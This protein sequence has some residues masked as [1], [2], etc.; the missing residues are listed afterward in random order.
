MEGRE[1]PPRGGKA[2]AGAD[3]E[4]R[5]ESQK[6]V[7]GG[8]REAHGRGQGAREP[9]TEEV[10]RNGARPGAREVGEEEKRI[11]R[12]TVRTVLEACAEHRC[13]AVRLEG[14]LAARGIRVPHSTIHAMLGAH[15]LTRKGRPGQRRSLVGHERTFSNSMWHSGWKRPRDGRHPIAYGDGASRPITGHGVFDRATPAN[16]VLVLRRA[17]GECGKPAPIIT[18]HG[19]QPCAVDAESR[20]R[21]PRS[22]RSSWRQVAHATC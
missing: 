22:S 4:D 7:R 10:R 16:A 21:A 5:E 9:D 11:A 3:R 19:A 17:I 18:D 8:R 15:G 12:T 13:G 20:R 14:I 6:H 2:D 1:A